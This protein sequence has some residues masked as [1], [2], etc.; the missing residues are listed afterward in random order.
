MQ[1]CPNLDACSYPGR[2]ERL[3]ELQDRLTDRLVLGLV[4]APGDP[5][6]EKAQW[7]DILLSGNA[8]V[9]DAAAQGQRRR[10]GLLRIGGRTALG[11][12]AA[13]GGGDAAAGAPPPP[14]FNTSLA[15]DEELEALLPSPREFIHL[16]REALCAPGYAGALCGECA[17]GFGRTNLVTCQRCPPAWKNSGYYVGVLVFNI[18]SLVGTIR[19]TILQNSGQEAHPPLYSQARNSAG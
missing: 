4:Y 12:G 10:R 9:V 6:L 2:A 1:P 16:Y 3:K 7:P 5:T 13:A 8:A 11:D 15:T 19:T 14:P 17:E 18:A